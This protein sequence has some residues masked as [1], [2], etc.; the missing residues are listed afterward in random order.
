MWNLSGWKKTYLDVVFEL[1]PWL[2][3]YQ[4][5]PPSGANWVQSDL[6]PTAV[7]QWSWSLKS[8]QNIWSRTD[9]SFYLT[10]WW[11][12]TATYVCAKPA[13]LSFFWCFFGGV[14]V[15]ST[16]F[17]SRGELVLTDIDK[18][19]WKVSTQNFIFVLFRGPYLGFGTCSNQKLTFWSSCEK[20]L[21]L[22]KRETP[23]IKGGGRGNLNWFFII[24]ISNPWEDLR[25]KE[26][27]LL[28]LILVFLKTIWCPPEY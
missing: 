23:R 3:F 28:Q 14:L 24:T 18:V 15:S 21:N 17:H 25:I 26:L 1:T 19:W 2:G 4:I 13:H 12:I 7:R 10:Y 11:M 22:M 16:R 9:N 6:A 20:A 27:N 8:F 5:N